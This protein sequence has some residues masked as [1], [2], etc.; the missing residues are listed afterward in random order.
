MNNPLDVAAIVGS[1]RRESYTRRLVE[2]LAKLAVPSVRIEIVGI[3]DLPFYNQDDEPAPPQPWVA[4][5]SRIKRADG[6]L[7]ATPE[8]NRSFPGSLKN[9]IDVGSRP[10]GPSVWAGRPA[11]VI[12]CSPGN[13]GGFGAH[14][15]LRQVLAGVDMATMAG[16][17]AYIAG[18]D[19]LFD[20]NGEFTNPATRDFCTK[21]VRTFESWIRRNALAV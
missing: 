2:A 21:F 12:S 10:W 8:Y 16:P 4:F 18:A 9:A 14:H 7:F 20:Q 11:A 15:H 3:G 19:K 1:L 13:I 6:V 17:E 5:R